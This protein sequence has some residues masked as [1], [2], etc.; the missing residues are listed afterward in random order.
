MKGKKEEITSNNNKEKKEEITIKNNKE[1]KS[2]N[3]AETAN[4]SVKSIKPIS[5]HKKKN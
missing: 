2:L 5:H 3:K 1:K 4:N